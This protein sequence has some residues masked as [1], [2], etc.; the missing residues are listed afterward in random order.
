MVFYFLFIFLYKNYFWV[1][2]CSGV[3]IELLY[4]LCK[5][6]SILCIYLSQGHSGS[7]NTGAPVRL[8]GLCP[9]SHT[10]THKLGH[11]SVANEEN[12]RTPRKHMERLCTDCNLSSGDHRAVRK[13]QYKLHRQFTLELKFYKGFSGLVPSFILCRVFTDRLSLSMTV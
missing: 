13:Y 5:K 9:Y 3:T 8:I 12:W 1:V 4:R 7:R 2:C 11:F 10:H 6:N